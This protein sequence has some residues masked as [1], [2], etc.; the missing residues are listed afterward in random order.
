MLVHS[1]LLMATLAR[2][3]S[4]SATP[5]PDYVLILSPGFAGSIG[6]FVHEVARNLS[7]NGRRD[8]GKE[9]DGSK[10]TPEGHGGDGF[11]ISR[12]RERLRAE[13]AQGNEGASAR[14][15]GQQER[16]GSGATSQTAGVEM[17]GFGGR[18]RERVAEREGRVG[19]PGA[20]PAFVINLPARRDRRAHMATLLLHL[21]F[22]PVSQCGAV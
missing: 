8:A 2:Y 7:V 10:G 12:F 14:G 3:K 16:A 15:Q 19:A 4:S 20:L 11:A 9:G 5:S 6:A 17:E 13:A 1:T 18:E 21:G 22:P